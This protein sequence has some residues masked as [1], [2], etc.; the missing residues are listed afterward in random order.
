VRKAVKTSTQRLEHQRIVFF[1]LVLQPFG[2]L[3][4][5]K[6]QF[7]ANRETERTRMCTGA[8]FVTHFDDG[9]KDRSRQG[10]RVKLRLN[11]AL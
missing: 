5:I 3:Y 10:E 2:E 9:Q 11:P 7:A 1:C 4:E 6:R 8:C